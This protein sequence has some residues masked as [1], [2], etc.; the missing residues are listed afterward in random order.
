M[1]EIMIRITWISSVISLAACADVT[2][3]NQP[4]TNTIRF[5]CKSSTIDNKSIIDNFY[6]ALITNVKYEVSNGDIKL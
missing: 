4:S 6:R 5:Q 3:A 1:K 2:R